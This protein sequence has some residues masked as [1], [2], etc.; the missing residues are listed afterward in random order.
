MKKLLHP[1][2]RVLAATERGATA[3]GR[4]TLVERAA[5]G[6]LGSAMAGA[7][8]AVAAG[9]GRPG[10]VEC[11][12]LDLGRTPRAGQRAADRR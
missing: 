3:W 12:V 6:R 10:P 9:R 7:R 1:L 5:P 2:S 11:L 4:W 8:E